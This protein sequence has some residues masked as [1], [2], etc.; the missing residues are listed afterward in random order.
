M[1]QKHLEYSVDNLPSESRLVCV[2][3]GGIVSHEPLRNSECVCIIALSLPHTRV[4]DMIVAQVEDL[5]I[6]VEL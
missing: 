1:K 4:E 2:F 5:N 6:V 3:V